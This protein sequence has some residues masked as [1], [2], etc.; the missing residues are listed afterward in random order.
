MLMPAEVDD[1]A[2]KDMY[3][4]NLD[5]IETYA[6]AETQISPGPGL[7]VI[8]KAKEGKVDAVKSYIEQIK[9]D[10]VGRAYY[11]EEIEA[12][13][14]SK[15]ETVGDIVYFALFNS[16]INEEAQEVLKDMLK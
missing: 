11:P 3:H 1:V 10:K 7:I 13:E 8:A 5:D 15:V 16:E 14:N 9:A 12:A 2:A 4:L 6:I